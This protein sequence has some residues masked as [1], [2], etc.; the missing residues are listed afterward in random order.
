VHLIVR[1]VVEQGVVGGLVCDHERPLEMEL[2]NCR[3]GLTFF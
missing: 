2:R 3:E 1:D